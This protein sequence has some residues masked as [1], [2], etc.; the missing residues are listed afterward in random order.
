MSMS[1]EQPESLNEWPEFYKGWVNL[2]RGKWGEIILD[3]GWIDE[4]YLDEIR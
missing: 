1:W 4:K 3:Q 2:S